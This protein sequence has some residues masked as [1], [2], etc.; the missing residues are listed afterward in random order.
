MPLWTLR[1]AKPLAAMA[2][3][4]KQTEKLIMIERT[5]IKIISVV[6]EGQII[7]S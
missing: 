2:N 4:S 5:L 6:N 1:I 3:D 7:P